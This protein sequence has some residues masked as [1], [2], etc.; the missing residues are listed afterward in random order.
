MAT[1]AEILRGY[2]PPTTSAL[3]DPIVEHF[4]NLPQTTAQN[5][6]NTNTMVQNSMPYSF[7]PRKPMFDPNPS[8]DPQAAKDFANYMPNMMGTFIGAGSKLWNPKLAFEAAK[9][10]KAKVPA[11]EIWK[12]TGTGRGLDNHWRQEISDA[13]MTFDPVNVNKFRRMVEA[14]TRIDPMKSSMDLYD[15]VKH[16]KLQESYPESAQTTIF[17]G[18]SGEGG[19]S[20]SPNAWDYINLNVEPAKHYFPKADSIDEMAGT[21]LHELQHNVQDAEGF[22]KGGNERMFKDI[23]PTKKELKKLHALEEKFMALEGGSPERIAAVREHTDLADKYSQYG[24][25]K[26]LA[27]EAEARLTSRRKLLD[28]AARRENY[29]FKREYGTGLDIDPNNALVLKEYG[30]PVI[31][32]KDMLEQLLNKQK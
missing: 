22:A 20:T 32:R 4:R 27:G 14:D 7:D 8:Y 12:Q 18:Q 11:E 5:A 31:T 10:E 2:Q 6:I 23:M 28:D 9:L 30:S 29:P 26:N 15:L 1:L 17:R 16:P 24:Q 13:D 3:A 21:L 19:G 25:Y